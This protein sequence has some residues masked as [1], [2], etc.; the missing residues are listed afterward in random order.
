MGGRIMAQP[1]SRPEFVQYCLRALGAPVIEI[2]VD[3]EQVEDRIDEAL[4]MFQQFHMD[5]T[6]RTYCAHPITASAYTIANTS[7]VAFANNDVFL[8]A[9]ASSHGKVHLY[10][11]ST[12]MMCYSMNGH[13]SVGET[14]HGLSTNATATITGITLGDMDNKYFTVNS[15]IISVTRI[16]PPFDSRISGEILFDPN[17]QFNIS[18]LTNFT[19]NSIVPYVVGR[20]YQQL[21][22]DTFR[23]RPGIRFERHMGRVYVDISWYATFRP[24]QHILFEGYQAINPETYQSVWTDRW[25]QRYSTSL[26]K[27]QWG[28][29]LL[30]YTNIMLP[31]NV[32]LDGKRIYDDALR[33]ISQLEDQLQSEFSLPVDFTMG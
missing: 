29:N 6:H 27:R 7:G 30:K 18:L 23:G 24:G 26:I 11:N 8:N 31:G 9:D 16:F 1:T 33:E 21:L 17:A 4:Y 19:S 3:E 20:Q 10:V 28:S 13:F 5:A 32:A 2:N 12:S 25:L 14:I 22:N 15:E